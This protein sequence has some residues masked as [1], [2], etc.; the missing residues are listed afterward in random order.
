MAPV[1]PLLVAL[2]ALSLAAFAAPAVAAVAEPPVALSAAQPAAEV[3]TREPVALA[4]KNAAGF[5]TARIARDEDVPLYN[6][7]RGGVIGHISDRTDLGSKR[8]LSVTKVRAGG[9]WLGVT[10]PERKTNRIAWVRND[11]GRFAFERTQLWLKADRSARTLMLIRGSKVLKRISVAIGRPG[12][13]TPLG[14]FAVTDKLRGKDY[15]NYYGCCILALSAH[16]PDTPKGWTGEARMA[17]HG[18]N[19]PGTVGMAASAG[20][21]RAHDDALRYLMGKVPLGTPVVIRR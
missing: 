16:Q 11:A 12:S 5:L 9:E 8:V 4:A 7:P 13:P 17:I 10:V 3:A 21:L 1:R 2:S 6:T 15:G 18:T 14:R 19:A 20:C